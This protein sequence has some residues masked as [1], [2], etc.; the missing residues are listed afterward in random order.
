MNFFF[1]IDNSTVLP[2][3]YDP[4]SLRNPNCNFFYQPL[5]L[6]HQLPNLANQTKIS[7]IKTNYSETLSG[8]RVETEKKPKKREKNY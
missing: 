2:L 5:A 1:C 8:T 6:N 4:Y 3:A 7:D